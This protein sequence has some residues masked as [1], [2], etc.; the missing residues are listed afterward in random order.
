MLS[1]PVQHL[2]IVC[3]LALAVACSAQPTAPAPVSNKT[4]VWVGAGD[5]GRC[6]SL[7]QEATA[8]LLD[9]LPGTVFAAG[10][11]AYPSGRYEDYVDCYHPSWGRHFS[12]TFPVPGNHEYET[13]GAA[14]YFQYFGARIGSDSYYAYSLGAWRVLALNSE[15]PVATGSAQ[16]LWLQAELS[17]LPA[18]GCAAAYWHRPFM[19][20]GPNG[21]NGDMRDLFTILYNRGVELVVAG[22]DHLY[23]RFE[24]VDANERSDPARGVRQFIVG[25]G[26]TPL[27]LPTRIRPGSES[28]G[29]AWGVLRFDLSPGSYRWEFVPA[30]STSFRDSGSGTCH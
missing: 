15:I 28:Q 1:R 14:G 27:S 22:H 8:A 23:E 3:V 30:E 29:V 16:G 17:A 5:I 19:S 25:T 18:G 2:C 13:P 21:D 7:G 12:R 24:P 26:G 11:N 10:D 9:R 4:E 20:S 6:G